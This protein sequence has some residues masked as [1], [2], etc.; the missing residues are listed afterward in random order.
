M[1]SVEKTILDRYGDDL[2]ASALTSDHL[3]SLDD[4]FN[5][6]E[7][8][9]LANEYKVSRIP[10]DAIDGWFIDDVTG[11]L[12]HKSGKF[13]SI[14]GLSAY[15]NFGN[16]RQWCQPII[17]QPEIGILGFITQKKGGVLHF[18]VQAKME[19]GNIN[20]LQISPTL[21]ATKS[22]YTSVHGGN[23]PAYL[24][25][26][27]NNEKSDIL[28]DQ[29]QSEQGA[30]FYRKRNRNIIIEIDSSEEIEV[31]PDFYWL[32]LG[33][34][35][36]LLKY[37]NIINMDSRTVL[38]IIEFEP[39]IND[40]EEIC[41]YFKLPDFSKRVLESSLH[42]D[43]QSYHRF[44]RVISWL[45]NLKTIYETETSF[46][47]LNETK[48]WLMLDGKITHKESRYFSVIGIS[49]EASNREVTCWQQP[50]IESAKGG[51]IAFICQMKN[52]LLHFLVQAKVE[53]GNFDT[54]ELAPTVQLTPQNYMSLEPSEM[55]RFYDL[56]LSATHE[57]VKYNQLQ[58]E[59]G[60]R[61]YHD[62]N[63]YQIIEIP[64]N[65]DIDIPANYI[66][67]TIKQIKSFIKFN[68]YFNIEAR[69]LL[70][71]LNY[72]NIE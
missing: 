43:E 19:P 64:E 65:M 24:E 63:R 44:N 32:T 54:V 16:T 57:Q 70:S 59:E 11:N 40:I 69:G 51:V 26:F 27:I 35:L 61:F 22:N 41:T 56:V 48:D 28:F 71:C 39:R 58:S 25:Y 53:P 10:V 66:W 17:S 20:L 37:D 45:T 21:Q 31:L 5:W 1:N 55:P 50:L 34:I 42:T 33:Q 29:L 13:F 67:M 49:V 18:L 6:F 68:N 38:S 47:P 8:R 30:R 60:G 62:E 12:H 15:T 23:K 4:F 9:R 72:R 36:D 52:G 3:C 7:R 2:L 46:I 14:V